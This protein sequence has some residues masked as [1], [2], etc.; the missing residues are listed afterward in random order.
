MA[1]R[2]GDLVKDMRKAMSVPPGDAVRRLSGRAIRYA[3]RIRSRRR[4]PS[5]SDADLL[6]ALASPGTTLAALVSRRLE[7]DPLVPASSRSAETARILLS[8]APES[9]EPILAAARTV[10]GGTFD[11]L[12]SGPV[13]LGEVPDWHADFKSGKRWEKEA[14]S[15]EIFQTPD[16]GHDIKVPWELSR[17]QHL[18]TLGIA[19]ALSGEARFRERAVAH[20]ASFLAENPVYRGVNWRCT[21]DVALRASQILAAEGYLRGAGDER[22]W[23]NLLK[24]LLLHARY[25]LD[26]LEDGPVRGNHYLSDLAGLYLCGLGLPELRE[27]PGWREF[28]RESLV[29]EMRRQVTVEGLDYEA[30]LSYHAFATEMFLFPALLGAEKGDPFPAP[31][32]EKLEKMLQAA[33]ILIRPDGTLP[34][35]GDNDDGRFLI[36]SQY[37]RP[38]RDWRPLMALGAFLFRRP[39]WLPLAGDAW[40]EGAWV[41]GGP[42][43]RWRQSLSPR[44][45]GP[46]PPFRSH[47]FAE[48][49]VYQLGAGP[50]QMVVDAGG[51]GQG[52]NGGH[53]HNDT[54]AFDL[55]AFGR[56]ILPDRGTGVYTP[57]LALRSRFRSTRA[58]NTIRVDGEEMNPFPEEP[59][60]LIPADSPRVLRWRLGERYAYLR[61]EHSGYRRLPGGVVHR[62]AILLDR[63]K[64]VFRIEDRLEGEGWHRFEGSFHLAPGW[65]AAA[66]EEGWTALD[67]EGRTEIRFTWIRRPAGGR[68]RVEEDLHSPSYGVTRKAWTVRAEWEGE[69]PCTIRYALMP[70]ERGRG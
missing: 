10:A 62:R 59:F 26:N 9:L 6:A 3:R 38:R 55:F 44:S 65:S 40:V 29:S 41:L 33:A 31:Y 12:G 58:H 69:A 35:I 17:L 49:G 5:L 63:A 56:E 8:E 45:G 27:A 66:G 32:L 24:A 2:L 1:Y 37:H 18:P 7:S 19:S 22:F 68:L 67:A 64:G 21:M 20:V 16:R 34:Q 61:A 47:A 52:G 25:I 50:V 60:R 39:E 54:L 53:A 36:F 30:S 48:A 57:D 43:V 15:L 28:G 13:G 46:F 23:S 42:F 11:L 70:L 51:V 14:H 4:I